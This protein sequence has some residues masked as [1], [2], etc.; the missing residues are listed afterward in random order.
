MQCSKGQAHSKRWLDNFI[1]IHWGYQTTTKKKPTCFWLKNCLN[2][3]PHLLMFAL[4]F[5][6]N[7]CWSLGHKSGWTCGLIPFR[8]SYFSRAGIPQPHI[9]LTSLWKQPFTFNH[10]NPSGTII[11]ITEDKV[12]FILRSNNQKEQNDKRSAPTH[13]MLQCYHKPGTTPTPEAFPSWR[14]LPP[15]VALQ[16]PSVELRA[17]DLYL[18]KENQFCGFCLGSHQPQ[19]HPSPRYQARFRLGCC[20]RATDYYLTA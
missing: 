3:L 19:C 20:F 8:C 9:S 18:Q 10:F 1:I 7:C 12:L 17:S 13:I 15:P 2:Q 16:H 11:S 4:F 6:G 14:Q 5:F